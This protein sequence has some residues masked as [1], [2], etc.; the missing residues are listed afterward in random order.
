MSQQLQKTRSTKQS[1]VQHAW[2]LI[3]VKDQVLGR[4]AP[5][6]A[7]LLRGKGKPYFVPNLDCGDTVVVIN[8]SQVVL[9]GNK[10][11][12]KTY[13][14]YSGYPGGLKRRVAGVVKET[15]PEE[16]VRHAVSGML[17]KNK[18]RDVWLTR[19]YIYKN[20]THPHAKQFATS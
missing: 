3:D 15:N 13:T 10:E 11:A 5:S 7:H 4:V 9:T 2:H 16:L 19:L 18:L 20:E 12:M 17:P 8:A 6:I 1:D 14:R